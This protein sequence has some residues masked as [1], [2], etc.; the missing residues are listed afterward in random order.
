MEW[1]RNLFYGINERLQRKK[2]ERFFKIQECIFPGIIEIIY[3]DGFGEEKGIRFIK[4]S[5]YSSKE[6]I[7]KAILKL[8]TELINQEKE[9]ERSRKLVYETVSSY[10]KKQGV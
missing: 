9:R 1:F 2:N 10:Q 7:D 5:D 6:E 8:K 4:A 3:S